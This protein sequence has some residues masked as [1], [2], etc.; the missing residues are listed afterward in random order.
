V[1]SSGAEP[2]ARPIGT[3]PGGATPG[4]GA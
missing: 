1:I 4:F 3:A 2:L